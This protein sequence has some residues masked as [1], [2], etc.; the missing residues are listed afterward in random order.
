[1]LQA[2]QSASMVLKEYANGSNWAIQDGKSI[3]LGEG[4]GPDLA[5][6]SL[7]VKSSPKQATKPEEAESN[8]T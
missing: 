2:L 3:W 1:M 6:A 4:D 8:G 5:V 7:G